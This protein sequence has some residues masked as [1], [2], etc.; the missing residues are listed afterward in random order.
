[1]K[2]SWKIFKIGCYVFAL[3]LIATAA[4]SAHQWVVNTS[5]L[6][7]LNQSMVAVSTSTTAAVPAIGTLRNHTIAMKEDGSV[8]GRF[9]IID[10]ATGGALGLANQKIFFIRN[11]EIAS[12]V[13]TNDDG[14]FVAGGMSPGVYSFVA[15]GD[16]G[17]ATF[18]VNVIESDND[19]IQFLEAS[20]VSL[21]PAEVRNIL[22]Q[23]LPQIDVEE[24]DINDEE[25]NP[26][27]IA[28]TNRVRLHDSTLKGPSCFINFK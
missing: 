3:P 9:S 15:A 16:G 6:T 24:L 21:R 1:M 27:K 14:T 11:G 10:R 12:Q 2:D 19:K 13:Y 17:F 25:V 8:E 5:P 7:A 18:G 22:S 23:Y 28:G 26:R 20:A 4:A